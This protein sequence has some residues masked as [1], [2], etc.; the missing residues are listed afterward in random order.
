MAKK[1]APKSK[2]FRFSDS[3]LE[4]L[5]RMAASH[6][7]YKNAVMAGLR[8]LEGSNHPTDK[9]LLDMLRARLNL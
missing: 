9:E 8:I 2:A 3:E 7:G 1:N 6:G 5:E 4:L